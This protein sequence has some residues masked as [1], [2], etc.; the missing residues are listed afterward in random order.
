MTTLSAGSGR[1]NTLLPAATCD[2]H[3][4]VFDSSVAAV[5]GAVLVPPTA[6]VAD[7]SVLQ[8]R[9]GVERNVFVQP[10]TYGTDNT[11]MLAAL[12]ARSGFARGVAVVNDLVTDAELAL[13]DSA[14]VIGV[15]FNQVQL[16]A[17]RLSMLKSLSPRINEL[18]WHVQMHLSAQQLLENA[19]MLG[20]AGV[21]V[22]L[23]HFARAFQSPEIASMV[24]DALFRLMHTER[25]WLKLSAPYLASADGPLRFSDLSMLVQALIKEFPEH[26]VWGTDWPH[27]TETEKPDDAH[28]LD[29]FAQNV[30]DEQTRNAIFVDNAARLYRFI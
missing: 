5:A 28:L 16:G 2:C 21:P 29:W 13:L 30:E 17:T 26:L 19:E 25:I 12:K 20:K 4:H 7:Y 9:L 15:R 24:R 8:A 11:L 23:D 1:P 14:G 6:T 22:V 27:A 18:G 3:M 10:S